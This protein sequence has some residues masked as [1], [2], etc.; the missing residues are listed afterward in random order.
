MK[1]IISII[2]SVLLVPQIAAALCV[3]GDCVNGQGTVVLPDGRRYVGEFKDGVRVGRGLMTFPD[4]TKYLGDWQNDKPDGQ[5]TLSSAGKFEYAGEFNNG[6]RHGQG[7]LETVDGKKYV[8]QWQND[9]PHGRGR[10]TYPDGSEFMGQFE[11]GRRNGE[12]EAKFA[13]GSRYSGLW[14][15]DLPNGQGIKTYADG[16]KYSGEFRNGLMHGTGTVVMPDGSEFIGQWQGDVLVKREDVVPETG[17]PTVD[18]TAG[19]V[20]AVVDE[21]PEE[22]KVIATEKEMDKVPALPREKASVVNTNADF[23]SVNQNGVFVRSGPSTEYRVVRSVYKGFPVQRIGSQDNW[24]QVRD[25]MGQEGWI[26][27]PLLG[28]ND[29]AVVTATKANLRSGNGLQYPVVSQVDYGTV[30]QVNNIVD[31]WYMVTT[32]GG[33]EGWLSRELVWPGGHITSS[34]D[35]PRDTAVAAEE[36]LHATRES[37]IRDEE[38]A[39]EVRVVTGEPESVKPVTVA[40]TIE[41][42]QIQETSIED[43]R[44]VQE[45][46]EPE[47]VIV[48]GD[49]DT[50]ADDTAKQAVE[51]GKEGDYASVSMNSRGANIRSEPSLAAEVLRSVPPGFPLLIVERQGD[52]V[53]VEDFRARRGWVYG[54]LLVGHDSVVIKVGK[55]NLRS[56]PGINDEIISKLDYAIVMTIEETRGEWLRVSNTEGLVGWLHK[57]VVWP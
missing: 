26:F 32:A 16:K 34:Q 19:H 54:S 25:F 7:T 43:V 56:G 14:K 38:M 13:D 1:L 29:S 21:K 24:T 51:T 50:G 2:V 45:P 12:G 35:S 4:G 28:S 18:E 30:L 8:G 57:D 15:D 41:K 40:T 48:H 55:G 44:V 36:S 5:G 11:N 42:Q 9:V 39:E 53:L 33:I 49:P 27:T 3:Q 52:W 6:V 22:V 47:E 37:A 46:V 23:A 17:Y 20:L 10:I 31:D